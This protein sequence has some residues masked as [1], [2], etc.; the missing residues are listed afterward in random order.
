MLKVVVGKK[1]LMKV[2]ELTIANFRRLE[3]VNIDCESTETVFVGP[4]NSGKTSATAIVRNFLGGKDFSIYDFSVGCVEIINHFGRTGDDSDFPRIRLDI[5]F[6][7]NPDAIEYG[8]AAALVP[9]L[10]DDFEELGVCLSLEV[11]DFEALR[12]EFRSAFGD[13]IEAESGPRLT[14]FL[15]D[16]TVFKRYFKTSFYALERNA[17]PNLLTP[18]VG[19]KLVDG[20]LR[21]DFIDAQRNID[22]S[23]NGR[24][25]QLSKAF[26][27][28]YEK[29]LEQAEAAKEAHSVIEENN[30]KL[31]AHYKKQFQP[32][33]DM[34]GGLGVP[35]AND[36]DL[37]LVSTLSPETALKGNTNLLYIDQAKEHELPEQYNGLGFKNLIYMAIQAKHF[38]AQW[39]RTA[40]DRPLCHLIFIEEPEVH[41]HAQVQQT[42]IQNIWEVLNASAKSENVQGRVP[43]LLVTTHSSHVLDAVDFAKVRY[44]SRCHL[45]DDDPVIEPV[46]NATEVKSLRKFRPLPTRDDD[47]NERVSSDEALAFL[48]RYLRLTH[49]DLFFSDAAILV[50]GAVE[51]LLLPEMMAK[52]APELKKVFLS[53]LEVGGAYAHRFDELVAFLNL[54]T[55]IIT[56][57]DAGEETGNHK[58]CRADTPNA[59]TTNAALK[60]FF[61]LT[62][63][64]ELGT[65]TIHDKCKN[66]PARCVIFQTEYK[67]DGITLLARTFEEDFVY[68]NVAKFRAEELSIGIKISAET[69][70]AYQEI[71]D[72]IRSSAIKKT[73][74]A[75]QVLAT[76]TDWNVPSYIDEGL[77]WL[78]KT[79]AKA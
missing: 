38:H 64:E 6:E 37:R 73:D 56:D 61:N 42:F 55:L 71:Y 44:F 3:K 15:D 16:K 25:N 45:A 62:K 27:D 30:E 10:S 5:W 1:I 35:S 43:Q 79:C 76:G 22:D 9:N 4:N 32:L 65:L 34:I 12:A 14:S 33:L 78:E 48:K 52:S 68:Q 7:V 70:V 50:E 41:I 18:T 53:L 60:H 24:G 51:K 17:A 66:S 19:K 23:D 39:A 59:V 28:F 46:L 29:N 58:A 69:A 67:T 31:S 21:V 74:F 49:C 57:L 40:K 72:H 13:D 26:S 20:L 36:R 2:K 77:K 75:M 11:E 8:R 54:P 47:D 63:V